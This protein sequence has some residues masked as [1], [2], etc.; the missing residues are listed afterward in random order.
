MQYLIKPV[1][2]ERFFE[3]ME[4][5][6]GLLNIESPKITITTPDGMQSL[7]FSQITYVEHLKKVLY[8]HMSN[9]QVIRTSNSSLTLAQITPDFMTNS[10]FVK[11]H[12]AFIVNMDYISIFSVS[13]LTMESGEVIPLS[14]KS[15]RD[16]KRVYMDYLLAKEVR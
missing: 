16:T 13:S 6:V 9:R 2:P 12:R 7:N 8:F 1:E 10:N 3:T 15:Y 11:P 4:K 14:Q 5:A